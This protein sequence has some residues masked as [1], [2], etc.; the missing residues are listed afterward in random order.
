MPT[1]MRLAS[2]RQDETSATPLRRRRTQHFQHHTLVRSI[3]FLSNQLQVEDGSRVP[4]LPRPHRRLRHHRRHLRCTPSRSG[5]VLPYS[6]LNS[7]LGLVCFFHLDFA[8]WFSNSSERRHQ[9]I[10]GSD[11]VNIRCRGEDQI[12]EVGFD[13]EYLFLERDFVSMISEFGSGLGWVRFG[14]VIFSPRR[15]RCVCAL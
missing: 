9:L 1:V 5:P 4:R 11:L 15:H 6:N 12:V 13:R 10:S 2:G 8:G 7:L 14:C 3:L